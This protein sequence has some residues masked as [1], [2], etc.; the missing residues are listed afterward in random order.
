MKTK[1]TK[2]IGKFS[3]LHVAL[4]WLLLLT[5]AV[6]YLSYSGY[7][8]FR[9][10]G[11]GDANSAEFKQLILEGI[12]SATKIPVISAQERKFIIPEIDIAFDYNDNLSDLRYDFYKDSETSTG[13]HEIVLTTS[14]IQRNSVYS[15][16]PE[17]SIPDGISNYFSCHRVVTLSQDSGLFEKEPEFSIEL[18]DGRTYYVTLADVYAVNC[19]EIYESQ[20]LDQF[21][22]LIKSAVPY[23]L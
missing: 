6:I 15:Q 20:P 9:D 18:S 7:I 10:T 17:T 23:Q 11:F 22:Q 8:R 14:M 16:T 2:Q 21:Y 12:T 19:S 1:K 5:V 3:L 4:L 13:S